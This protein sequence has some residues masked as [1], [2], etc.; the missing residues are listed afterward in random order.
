MK[1]YDTFSVVF[2]IIISLAKLV[3]VYVVIN[4]GLFGKTHD[5]PPK[6]LVSKGFW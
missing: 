2:C 4:M 3:N 5:K 6:D 1:V